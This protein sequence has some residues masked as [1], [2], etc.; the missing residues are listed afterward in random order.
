MPVFEARRKNQRVTGLHARRAA[1]PAGVGTATVGAP[2]GHV[3]WFDPT[4][5]RWLSEDPAADSNLYR[6]CGNAPTDGTD[7]SGLT[8]IVKA[9]YDEGGKDVLDDNEFHTGGAG[10]SSYETNAYGPTKDGYCAFIAKRSTTILSARQAWGTD[11][12]KEILGGMLTRGRKFV[13]E[14]NST[15]EVKQKL[16]DHIAERLSVVDTILHHN[17]FHHWGDWTYD[18]AFWT[19]DETTLTSASDALLDAVN[20]GHGYV[21]AGCFAAVWTNILGGILKVHEHDSAY[22]TWFTSQVADDPLSNYQ[23]VTD[24]QEG[25]NWRLWIPGDRGYITNQ[26]YHSQ[27]HGLQ[28]HNMVSG[29]VLYPANP[30]TP[31]M[32]HNASLIPASR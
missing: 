25:V 29:K 24:C 9:A 13:I 2:T 19:K 6:Y 22:L 14:G 1:R 4:V 5:G 15:G 23:N 32:A 3:R 8:I 12:K 28:G 17:P 16:T 27:G 7:P 11:T 21:S 18:S 30:N 31:P 10:F 20:G 26:D